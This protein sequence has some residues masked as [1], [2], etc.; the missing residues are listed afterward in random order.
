MSK[1][2]TIF[3]PL[4]RPQQRHDLRLYAK[5]LIED[6]IPRAESNYINLL[7]AP[8]NSGKSYYLLKSAFECAAYGLKGKQVDQL[9]RQCILSNTK[10][11]V[12]QLTKDA[13]KLRDESNDINILKVNIFESHEADEF[14]RS[15][16]PNPKIFFGTIQQ[17]SIVKHGLRDKF[18]NCKIDRIFYDE[19]DLGGNSDREMKAKETQESIKEYAATGFNFLNDMRERGTTVI[20]LTAT[21]LK[22][23]MGEFE[24]YKFFSG[25]DEIFKHLNK[26]IPWPTQEELTEGFKQLR[27]LKTYNS[28][29]V[30]YKTIIYE[31]L[32][33]HFDKRKV[34]ELIRNLI[35][36]I[37]PTAP[38]KYK[39]VPI[40]NGGPKYKSGKVSPNS[41]TVPDLLDILIEYLNEKCSHLFTKDCYPI[42]IAYEN[43][44]VMYNLKGKSKEIKTW[45]ECSEKLNDVNDP[46]RFVCYVSKIGRG[47]NIKTIDMVVSPRERLQPKKDKDFYRTQSIIQLYGRAIR[48]NPGLDESQGLKFHFVSEVK[49]W[50]D[51]KYHN[52]S[53]YEIKNL[54][55]KYFMLVNSFDI[56][57]PE[58]DTFDVANALWIEKYVTGIENSQFNAHFSPVEVVQLSTSTGTVVTQPHDQT[59]NCD[60]CDFHNGTTKQGLDNTFGI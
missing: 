18:L 19:A 59:C 8:T 11:V 47:V 44:Y 3:S 16:S 32:D 51:K 36:T 6:A 28:D 14:I 37:D 20:C 21:P 35:L 52:D 4:N 39:G 7:D 10:S 1:L 42:L 12:D 40:F 49:E 5:R 33:M 53:D 24:M 38:L 43:K 22:E 29:K 13:K 58:N 50:L 2:T 23:Q 60:K 57:S 54:Y 30:S 46:L 25:K 34:I 31:A 9:E 45:N 27:N 41:I 48:T 55:M 15:T 17:L 26:D 56:L